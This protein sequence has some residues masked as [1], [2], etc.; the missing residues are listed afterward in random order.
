M[1]L[2][3]VLI[4]G[5]DW[6]EMIIFLSEEEAIKESSKDPNVRIEIFAKSDRGFIPTYNYYKDGNYFSK[7]NVYEDISNMQK[8]F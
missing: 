7:S 5:S 4:N 6:E 3:Y 2:I 1:N 8:K